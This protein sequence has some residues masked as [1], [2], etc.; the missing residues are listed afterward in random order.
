MIE[1]ERTAQEARGSLNPRPVLLLLSPTCAGKHAVA[2]G[3]H[4]L[5]IAEMCVR[6][7]TREIRPEDNGTTIHVTQS[8][9]VGPGHLC[10]MHCYDHDYGILTG[11]VVRILER[12]YV[13]IL[14][15]MVDHHRRS[16][17]AKLAKI[18]PDCSLVTVFLVTDPANA[19]EVELMRRGYPDAD[20]RILAS[21][22]EIAQAMRLDGTRGF[23]IVTNRWNNL[24]ATVRRIAEILESVK[25]ESSAQK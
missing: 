13:P 15:G 3:L 7:T 4:S 6:L 17:P 20:D 9:L 18:D 10:V 5:G 12:G 21:K 24:D 25:A 19:W 11:E 14:R 8:E 22:R 16:L 23:H 1:D 2:A